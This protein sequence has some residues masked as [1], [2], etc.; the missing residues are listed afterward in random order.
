M[1]VFFSGGDKG[2]TSL[3]L[4]AVASNGANRRS[5]RD[6]IIIKSES[7][8]SGSSA[9][10]FGGD[11]GIRTPDLYVANVSRYQLCYIPKYINLFGGNN[12]TRTCDLLH[13]KQTL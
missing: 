2:V 10:A 4:R 6:P 1:P 3:T 5:S 8:Q 11:K 9:F 12:G 7:K 13:V